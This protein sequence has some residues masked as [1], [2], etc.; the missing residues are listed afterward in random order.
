MLTLSLTTV[1]IAVTIITTN[2]L[3]DEKARAA[4][5]IFAENLA[6][7]VANAIVN[8]CVLKE[9]Y[10]NA[11]YSSVLD[12]PYKLVDRY[13]YY[14]E[15]DDNAVYVKSY[16]G[17][18]E[19]KSTIYNV[20]EEQA[21]TISGR[22]DGAGGVINISCNSYDYVYRFDFGTNTSDR[23]SGYTR[24]TNTSNN[25]NWV[26]TDNLKEWK[27]R[28]PIIIKN[29]VGKTLIKYQVLIQLDDTNFD[30]SLVNSNGSDLRFIDKT[31][32][33]LKYWIERWYPRDTH[34]SRIWVN[35]TSLSYPEDIIYMYHGNVSASPMSNGSGTFYF[36]DDF[37]SSLSPTNWTQYC[38]GNKGIN[39]T[40][41]ELVLTNGAAINS[42]I[43]FG[44][45][46]CVIETKAKSVGTKREAS[47]FAK[48][49]GSTVPPYNHAY[50]FTSGNFATIN[51]NLSI[52]KDNV[53]PPNNSSG[54]PVNQGWNRLIYIINGTDII[55]CRYF[56]ENYTI[57]G[58]LSDIATYSGNGYFGLCT[59]ES[60]TVAY[61]DWIFVRK[62]EANVGESVAS[63]EESI[64]VAYICGTESLNYGWN[65]N[66]VIS[67]EYNTQ[68]ISYDFICNSTNSGATFKIT[69]LTGY[70]GSDDCSLVFTVGDPLNIVEG[71]TITIN[72]VT[73]D[74]VSCENSYKKILISNILPNPAEG[75][76]LQIV[77]N[78]NPPGPYYW[79]VGDLIIQHGK[80]IIN[81]SGGK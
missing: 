2:A 24:V 19:E 50:I 59:T 51:K 80:R 27:Y 65:P 3:I 81:V 75:G 8:V 49:D 46:P 28:T 1:I 60:N 26:V 56:Y 29:P 78:D 11:N 32:T 47:I 48:N 7:Q 10:P 61:Y 58:A 53:L 20:T 69:N 4:A 74:V 12:I 57:D 5:D 62:F 43:Q 52:I 37:T 44:A 38:P 76:S 64:P 36:F 22:L 21:T 17:N 15:I 16:D 71:M 63:K 31:G 34:T 14:I 41:G 77:F 42:T 55:V 33:M 67:K 6:N 40:N 30:Y 9:Q 23:S 68:G 45:S 18:I 66:N 13:S 73:F 79:A 72:G 54:L 25:N 70:L 39:I 35:L